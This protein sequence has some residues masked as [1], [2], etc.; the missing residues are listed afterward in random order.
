MHRNEKIYY[1]YSAFADLVILTPIIVLYLTAKG[2]S[3]TEILL[4]DSI[5]AI[6]IFAFEVPTGALAD[7]LGRK[8][9]LV[10]GGILCCISLFIYIIGNRFA[11]FAFAEVLF[12][13]GAAFKSG[14]DSALIYDSLK[15]RQQED[16]YLKVEGKARSFALYTLAFGSITAG[17]AYEINIHLPL[18]ISIGFIAM[19]VL[20]ALCFE[21][22]QVGVESEQETLSDSK[23]PTFTMS[24]SPMR[25]YFNQIRESGSY[26]VRHPKLRSVILFTMLF[27]TFYRAGFWYVQP[28]MEAVH[29]PV[30]YFGIT[31]FVFNIAAAYA[32]K[33]SHDFINWTKSRTLGVL[34]G[35]LIVS[36]VFIASL[37]IW[38]GVLFI[39]L[40]QF[41]K[42]FYRPVTSKYMNKYIPSDK[43]ATVLSFQSLCSNLTVALILPI[44]GVLKDK[45][46]IFTAH[47]IL[48]IVMGLLLAVLMRYMNKHMSSSSTTQLTVEEPK[49]ELQG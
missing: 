5:L 7:K 19:S 8:W 32:S 26:A 10:L 35:L 41:A 2:L 22:K 25:A 49:E 33:R 42:G 3:F 1:W 48:A 45:S 16:R 28:Y 27:Y 15:L 4:I 11:V 46:D 43:R 13:F 14:A 9:C 38:V 29:I 17:F 40:Q 24:A 6:A 12:G 23:M 39:L 20:F 34:G 36:Y 47:W 18:I 44:M 37:H 31:F 30:S 21:E